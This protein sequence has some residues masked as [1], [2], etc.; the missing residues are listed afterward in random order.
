VDPWDMVKMAAASTEHPP[1][2]TARVE[3]REWRRYRRK[4]PLPTTL[5]H[6]STIGLTPGLFSM[7]N[8]LFRAP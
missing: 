2:L 6:E 5:S 4:Y 3:N 1:R 8:L 7:V